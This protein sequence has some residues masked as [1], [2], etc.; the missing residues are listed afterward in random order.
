MTRAKLSVVTVS[1][2][3]LTRSAGSPMSTPVSIPKLIARIKNVTRKN[4]TAKPETIRLGEIEISPSRHL[5]L[6]EGKEI[7]FPKKEFEVLAYLAAHA[8]QV[9]NRFF[10]KSADPGASS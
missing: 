8:E 4:E 2:K 5:V 9:V 7:F 1:N 3:P 6:V 10:G